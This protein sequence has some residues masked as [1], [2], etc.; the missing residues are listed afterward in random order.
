[1]G[2]LPGNIERV[3]LVFLNRN[4]GPVGILT[5]VDV[6]DPCLAGLGDGE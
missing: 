3:T 4:S 5:T 6:L 1:M 2:L